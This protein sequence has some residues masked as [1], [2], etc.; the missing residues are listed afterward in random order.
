MAFGLLMN[1][2]F[3][4]FVARRRHRPSRT[5]AGAPIVENLQRLLVYSLAT[6]MGWDVIRAITNVLL[7]LL[8]GPAVLAVLRRTARRA[9]FGR[10]AGADRAAPRRCR[11]PDKASISRR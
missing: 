2:W 3:W 5:C 8:L 4:P 6:S 9:A 11:P 10:A 1:L 7:I